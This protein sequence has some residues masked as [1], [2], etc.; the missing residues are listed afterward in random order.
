MIDNLCKKVA[1]IIIAIF[2]IFIVNTYP[3]VRKPVAAGAFYPSNKYELKAMINNFLEKAGE[4]ILKS[5]PNILICPHAGY[6]YSGQVAAYS[7]KE[8]R[9]FDYGTIILIGPSHID[10]FEFASVYNGDYYE[11]PLGKIP[12]N[13][14]LSK[15]ITNNEKYIKLSNRGHLGPAFNRG[16]HCLEVE[17]PF[18]QVIKSDI[19]IVPI[20]IGTMNYKVIQALGNKL[21]ET[22]KNDNILIV[23]SSDLSHYHSYEECNKIDGRLIRQLKN[24][25][26]E[27]FYYGLISKDYEACGGAAITAALIAAKKAGINSIKILKHANSGDVPATSKDRVVGYLAAAIFKSKG[28][29]KM[30]REKNKKETLLQ[31]ELNKQDQIYLIELAEETINRVV[32]G[33]PKPNP[34]DVPDK[35]KEERGAFVTINKHG[36]L[37]GCIGY[38]LP[39]YPLYKTVIEA[40]TGAA[41]HDPR[42]KPVSP[43]ELDD[44]EVEISV[45]TV[46]E[47]I[48]DPEK[49][50]VGKHGL[51][52]KRGFYQGLLLPQVAVEYGWDRETFLEHTCLK[53]GLPRNAWK[54]PDTEISIFSAQVFSRET[55]NRD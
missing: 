15:E 28:G 48:D 53:A 18:I 41:L 38:V 7:F 36:E 12:I 54:D 27:K 34:D 39:V 30:S 47:K 16:E 14:D 6:I 46:P 23:V 50:E 43:D 35:L 5:K 33:K 45:L 21:G 22:L 2:C 9:P 42:F 20:I 8:I 51:I 13:K 10:Y 44:I 37:R 52:I 17:L 3:Q 24:M 1:L 49:I 26:P 11:T 19:K 40:A 32:N 55:L 29:G 4:P 25:D 31:G